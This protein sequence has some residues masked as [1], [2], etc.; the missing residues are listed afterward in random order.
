MRPEEAIQ[1]H[2][3]FAGE[4]RSRGAYVSSEA[5]GGTAVATTVR[6]GNGKTIDHG[7]TIRGGEG[8]DG[9]LLPSRL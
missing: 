9:R 8:S 6:V 1:A 4:A 2:F 5:I 3:A 7:R